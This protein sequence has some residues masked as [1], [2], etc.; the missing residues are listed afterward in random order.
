MQDDWHELQEEVKALR[1]EQERMN[2]RLKVVY[3]WLAYIEKSLPLHEKTPPPAKADAPAEEAAPPAAP[4]SADSPR[5]SKRTP[6]EL[7]AKIGGIW[8]N[9][10]GII[11]FLLGAAFFLKLAY[12]WGWIN[13]T[14]RLALG[15]VVAAILLW[16]GERNRRRG[17]TAYGQGLTGGGIALLY[18]TIFA[19][20]YYYN[21]V[22]STAGMGLLI[23]VT[24]GAVALALY[25]N[26]RA[27]A[28][29]GL[30]VNPAQAQVDH[31][32]GSH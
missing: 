9:R 11:I 17:F 25:Q 27:V 19:S 23:L 28:V 10:I 3:Q 1:E 18:F 7:E 31:R 24:V 5:P 29:I 15:A 2:E 26:A 20:F 13:E 14:A 30:Q 4:P 32:T 21:L 6:Q 22:S 8:L 12:D 16:L